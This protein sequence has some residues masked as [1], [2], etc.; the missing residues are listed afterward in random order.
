MFDFLNLKIS[1]HDKQVMFGFADKSN[2]GELLPE[3]FAEAWEYL[4][5]DINQVCWGFPCSAVALPPNQL[6]SQQ[7]VADKIGLSD[8]DILFQFAFSLTVFLLTIPF[9][10]TAIALYE[11]QGTFETVVYT[12][13]GKGQTVHG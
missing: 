6:C 9:L 13:F 4:K 12:A 7:R 10:F 1:E 8:G 5:Q 3:E 11:N 2:R